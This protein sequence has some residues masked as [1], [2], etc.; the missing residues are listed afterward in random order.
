MSRQNH[1]IVYFLAWLIIGVFFG[2]AALLIRGDINFAINKLDISNNATISANKNTHRGFSDAVM[3]AAP[4]V[5][6]IQTI[7]WSEP[8][9]NN[10]NGEKFTQ[11]FLGR[12]SPHRP[13]KQADT[14]SGS[15]VIMQNNGYILTNYHVIRQ[16][17]E[18][19]VRLSDGRVAKAQ[20]VGSDPDTDVAI[21]KINLKNLPSL[22][23]AD[24]KK[25]KVGDVVLAIGDP[26]A[27]GQTVTQGII[28]ATGRTRVSQNT[29]ENF[30]QTDAAIN[31]GNSGGALINTKGEIVGI[32]SNIFSSSG[33]FQ[34][35]SF[36]I[37]ID[38]AL[39][40]AKEIIQYGYVVRGWLG[41]EGQELTSQILRSVEL[42]SMH[43]ILITDVDQNGPGDLAGIKRGDIIT[44]INQ[45]KILSTNDILNMIAAGRPGDEFIIEGLRK[46]QSFMTKAV[47]GQRPVMSR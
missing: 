41:V 20:L 1:T 5:V 29:Y 18:V 35:I 4:A 43:G 37:P 44:K 33:N 42:D 30:I 34:G 39:H 12:N 9:A 46:R 25:L 28:S 21:L 8:D 23:I 24:I 13:T 36:A 11:R 22:K 47:L 7:I 40:V 3:K 32:N 26:F 19:R 15:G 10:Q 27:I 45:Q 6:S 31:P 38:L 14:S 17:D 2:F 16:K